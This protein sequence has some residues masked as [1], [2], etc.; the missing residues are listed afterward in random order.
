MIRWSFIC[1]LLWLEK[2]LLSS[3]LTWCHELWANLINVKRDDLLLALLLWFSTR[4]L[5]SRVV[6]AAVDVI[7]TNDV[8]DVLVLL[9]FLRC[10]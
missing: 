4:S 7:A 1:K 8:V 9:L 3:L 6:K 2:R 10:T 5:G